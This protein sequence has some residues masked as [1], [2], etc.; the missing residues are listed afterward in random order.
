[1]KRFAIVGLFLALAACSSAQQ[2]TAQQAMARLQTDVSNGCL[3]VQPTLVSVQTLDPDLAPFV[4]ANGA[5]CAANSTIN[6]TSIQAMV[7]TSIP[8]AEALVNSSPLI[9][10]DK[11]PVVV[12]A[13]T[14]F[15]IALS[16][17]LVIYSQSAPP[18]VAAPVT[19]AASP[20]GAS[21]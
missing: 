2:I 1:M 8:A 4:V 14:A 13:L 12:G 10:T 7:N 11:K 5:F 19:P 9:P 15:Q 21:T 16:T 17:A 18:A 6:V 20:L 3:I